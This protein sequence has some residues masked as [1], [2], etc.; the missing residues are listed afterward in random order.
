M[1]YCFSWS[2]SRLS[3]RTVRTLVATTRSRF[4]DRL[5]QT[6]QSLERR[7]AAVVYFDKVSRLPGETI[8]RK[9]LPL[10]VVTRTA[11][12]SIYELAR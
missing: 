6:R 12:G 11:D 7:T 2:G 4:P 5:E 8:L 1:R 9:E 10:T 3:Y